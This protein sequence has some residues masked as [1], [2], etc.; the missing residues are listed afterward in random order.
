MAARIVIAAA[1]T[2]SF[3]RAVLVL[4]QVGDALVSAKTVERVVH[5]VGRELAER[6]DLD[7]KSDDA[8]AKRPAEPPPLAVVECDGGRI[9]CRQPG[10]GPGV[11]L[12][13][14]GWRENKNACLIRATHQTFDHDPQPEPPAC[15]LDPRHVAQLA[16]TAAPP[17]AATEPRDDPRSDDEAP[18]LP[19]EPADWRP[20]RLVRTVLSSL[21][22]PRAFGRQMQREARRRRFDEAQAKVYLGDG[23]PW[24]WSIWKTHFGDYTPILDFIHA[25]SYLFATARAVHAAAEDAWAQ[26][27]AWMRGAWRGEIEQVL[28]EL[29]AWQTRLGLPPEAAGEDDPRRVLA[30]TIGYLTNNRRRMDYAEYRRQGL[31]VTTAW[32]ESLVKEINYRVKGTEMFWN[33]PEGAEAILQV[34]AAALSDDDRLVQHLRTRPGS[35]FTRQPK[36]RQLSAK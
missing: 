4:R 20:Q 15:F 26:Y 9:R 30:S 8:L 21:A 2:R 3:R 22:D 16:E 18:S 34:R 11:H 17:V 27:E 5:D 12:E 28:E 29:S 14:T 7:P 24:N 35:P 25:L 32:M 13:G 31:P 36:P 23:L 1:E 19:D 33:D 6:R 10:Q